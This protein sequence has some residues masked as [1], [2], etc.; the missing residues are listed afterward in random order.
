MGP[1]VSW[2]TQALNETFWHFNR[3]DPLIVD[4]T[5]EVA[6]HGIARCVLLRGNAI[7]RG[8]PAVANHKNNLRIIYVNLMRWW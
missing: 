6:L 2:Q 8:A 7:A 5:P 1:V 4:G 3:A